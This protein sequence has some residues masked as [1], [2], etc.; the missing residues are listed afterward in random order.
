MKAGAKTGDAKIQQLKAEAQEQLTKYC[1][2][3]KLRK[4]IEKTT[5]IKLVLIFSGHKLM[6]MD[7]VK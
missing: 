3:E 2:D 5:L 7:D 1:I 4:N 6:Y